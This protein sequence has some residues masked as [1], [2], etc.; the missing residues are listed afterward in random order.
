MATQSDRVLEKLRL[1]P[2]WRSIESVRFTVRS[3]IE[4]K[5][6]G[7]DFI[8]EVAQLSLA[9]IA[10]LPRFTQREI[11]EVVD[12]LALNGLELAVE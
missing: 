1:H 2:T 12:K 5:V 8:E 6:L 9:Q 10:A 11:D 4:L 3:H 7:L